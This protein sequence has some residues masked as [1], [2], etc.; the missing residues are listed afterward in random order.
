MRWRSPPVD[1]GF[2]RK[3]VSGETLGAS[4]LRVQSI[5]RRQELEDHGARLIESIMSIMWK[6]EIPSEGLIF[7][8]VTRLADIESF[9]KIFI[10]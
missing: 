8:S 10:P 3:S 5:V 1:V 9:T 2:Q 7:W 6:M 4:N